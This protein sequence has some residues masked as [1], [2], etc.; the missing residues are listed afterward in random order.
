MTDHQPTAGQPGAGASADPTTGGSQT[1]GVRRTAGSG[2]SDRVGRPA[3]AGQSVETA[4]SPSSMPSKEGAGIPTTPRDLT[5]RLLGVARP[6]VAPLG[7]SVACRMVELLL[8][9]GLFAAGGWALMTRAA[10]EPTWTIGAT[11]AMLAA[12]SLLKGLF[13][14]LEQFSG[15]WV[16]FRSLA[17]LRGYFF[18]RLEPQAPAATEGRDSGDLMSRVTRDVDRIEVFFAHT[19][20]PG[21]T[22]V[23]APV[24]VVAWM[25]VGVSW[26]AALALAAGL[27]LM[28]LVVPRWGGARTDRAARVVREGRGELAQHVTDSVQGVREVLAFGAQDARLRSMSAIE[29]R[30]AGAQR[31]AGRVVAARRGANRALQGATL[32]GVTAVLAWSSARG[33]VSAGQIG[34]G[35]GLAL[36]SFASVLAVEDFQADLD[37]AFAS[38]RR[39]F[40]VTE[41]APLVRDPVEA[42]RAATRAEQET[43]DSACDGTGDVVVAGV[44]FAYPEPVGEADEGGAASR[45]VIPDEGA[46]APVRRPEVLHSVSLRFPAGRTTAVVGASGSGKSTLAALVERMWDVDAGAITLGGADVRDLSRNRLRELVALAPQQPYL[47]NDTVRANLLLARPSATEEDLMRACGQVGLTEWLASEPDGLD[48]AVGERGER[49]SGGQQ[50]RV[51]LARALLREAPVTI[52]DE[53]TSQLDRDTEAVV[54][55]GIRAATAGRTLIVIAHRIATVTDADQIA[56]MDGGRVVETGTFAELT[57]EGRQGGALAALLRREDG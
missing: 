4:G 44:S 3:R 47:F 10:G 38:A 30:I 42:G 15:H 5:R 46:P 48:T 26:W 53:A 2:A 22:A 54:L 37:Q 21:V 19:L 40:A 36:G 6:V 16:A 50:Q 35:L 13:R 12:M 1:S 51:A 7:L 39:V 17:L 41:R 23:L 29:G 33:A 27:V 45:S 18:D 28:G 55:A 57:A 34:L 49:L 14:Y 11:V 8:G 31:E 9:V 25:G 56:V 43:A 32:V 20:A 24:C 52:L